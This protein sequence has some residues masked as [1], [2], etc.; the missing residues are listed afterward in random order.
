MEVKS[1]TI[2][3]WQLIHQRAAVLR[4][5]W[6][7]GS[8]K[9]WAKDFQKP[10]KAL[11][12]CDL[13]RSHSDV[14]MTLPI[15]Y[16][17]YTFKIQQFI[18]FRKVCLE[19]KNSRLDSL[20]KSTTIAKDPKSRRLHSWTRTFFMLRSKNS[21]DSFEVPDKHV[22]SWVVD[23]SHDC[24]SQVKW[25]IRTMTRAPIRKAFFNIC[26]GAA[27]CWALQTSAHQKW[28]NQ[29][30]DETRVHLHYCVSLSCTDTEFKI[31]LNPWE[32]ARS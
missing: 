18:C 31:P 9:R 10:N 32:Q 12:L 21:T 26:H 27:L 24:A 22:D 17:T 1:L 11:E 8:Q 25:G 16:H 28:D 19:L 15:H 20:L 6:K 14:T 2:I 4:C 23:C 3:T 5:S 13:G 7:V 29:L 30:V